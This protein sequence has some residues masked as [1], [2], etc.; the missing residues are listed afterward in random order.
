MGSDVFDYDVALSF[1]GE[2]RGFVDKIANHLR[3][4]G[5]KVFYDKYFEVNLW[6]KDLYTYLGEVYSKKSRYCVLFISKHYNK[7]IWT[8]H[9]REFAQERAFREINEYILP[10]RI[11]NVEIPG[12]KSTVGFISASKHDSRQIA[13]LIM[14]K[15]G[16]SLDHAPDQKTESKKIG[17]ILL[18]SW[19]NSLILM[20]TVLVTSYLLMNGNSLPIFKE[21]HSSFLSDKKEIDLSVADPL[22]SEI[23]ENSI[24]PAKDKSL[25]Q[26]LD[27]LDGKTGLTT[28]H[29]PLEEIDEDS[30]NSEN[31]T[32]TDRLGF[33][34]L[35]LS[36]YKY[37]L[38]EQYPAIIFD[39]IEILDLAFSHDESYL[40]TLGLLSNSARIW[41]FPK[42]KI[43]SNRNLYPP[44]STGIAFHPKNKDVYAV[45]GEGK[46]QLET[47]RENGD[48]RIL[49]K[50]GSGGANGNLIF[51]SDGRYLIS[52]SGSMVR[53]WE[54]EQQN[55]IAAFE[56]G[57]NGGINIVVSR[58]GKF[59]ATT[60]AMC[61]S[62][63]VWNIEA[64]DSI[65][66]IKKLVK[67]YLNEPKI[68]LTYD[69]KLAVRRYEA[70]K[71]ELEFFNIQKTEVIQDKHISFSI[72]HSGM[73][74]NNHSSAWD[75]F[76]FQFF[77][78]EPLL[79]IG[80][81]KKIEI[82]DYMRNEM[83]SETE[84]LNHSIRRLVVSPTGKYIV[85]IDVN[86]PYVDNL[87]G[88]ERLTVYDDQKLRVFSIGK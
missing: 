84:T 64:M 81:E 16:K 60:G 9:E 1:A 4:N 18:F 12:L 44:E 23:D 51:S 13:D 68:R 66:L 73:H 47:G 82:W 41:S 45:R 42:L 40:G 59:M 85:S 53:I 11:D 29:Q 88:N 65:F 22:L 80:R 79:V 61:T 48:N 67:P 27:T 32:I 77:Q 76:D 71:E 56:P 25:S 72:V 19:W 21:I 70:G 6:G 55:L 3:Q 36:K 57:C 31:N 86:N 8:N 46:I 49:N 34:E 78:N 52:A 69:N 24:E 2:D 38:L 74:Q 39:S 15:I 35:H 30:T 14:L 87:N 58:N 26:D 33:D 63:N 5:V 17:K 37:S 43:I 75:D 50:A 54:W 10:V 62:I 28:T 83:I 7:K 20:T